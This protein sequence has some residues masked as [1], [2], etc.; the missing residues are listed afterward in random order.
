MKPGRV[1]HATQHRLVLDGSGYHPRNIQSTHP[2]RPE[3][4]SFEVALRDQV[5]IEERL[6]RTGRTFMH[7]DGAC[8]YFLRRRRMVKAG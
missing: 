3:Q 5:V 4:H 1:R 8:K 6:H 2:S 7:A